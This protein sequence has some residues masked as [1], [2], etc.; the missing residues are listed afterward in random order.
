MSTDEKRIA[1]AKWILET[2]STILNEVES[3][4]KTAS[5]NEK[6]F[7]EIVAYT[8]KGIPL[9]KE[10]YIKKIKEAEKGKFISSEELKKKMLSW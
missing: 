5:E 9:S 4:Y 7:S 1:L 6:H 8:V 3:I 10:I 2:D